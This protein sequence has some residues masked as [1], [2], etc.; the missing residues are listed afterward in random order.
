M[1]LQHLRYFVD[2]ARLESISRAAEHNHVAQPSMS[3]VVAQLEKEFGV[4]LFDRVGRKIRLNDCGRILLKAAEQSLSL[5]DAV[6]E[7]IDYH[8]GQLTGSVKICFSCP[9]PHFPEILAFFRS[10]YPLVELDIQ[11]PDLGE[12]IE[13]NS[14]Y[15][16]FF[17]MGAARYSGDYVTRP[18]TTYEL[19]AFMS[20]RNPLFWQ[21]HVTLR[22]LARQEFILPGLSTLREIIRG[23]CYQEGFIP[24]IIG[25]ASH[26]GGQKLLLDT[27]AE[28]R[29]AL[30]LRGVD[31]PWGEGYKLMP[32]TGPSYG[33]DVNAA[34]SQSPPLRPSAEAFRDFV[35]H[36][37]SEGAQGILLE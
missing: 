29:V 9:L 37:Y 16:L 14:D 2:I 17:Y 31:A 15:D 22:E 10:I 20:E 7:E 1:E 5:L 25:E 30:A 28:R 26:P 13:L 8:N 23:Y 35:L 32:I 36:Y 34:W 21:K 33:V 12:S 18:L 11:K 4:P 27:Q 24:N 3:R 19:A 6:Q